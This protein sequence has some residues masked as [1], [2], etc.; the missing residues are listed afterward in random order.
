MSIRVQRIDHSTVLKPFDCGDNELNE[1]LQEKSKD[2][3]HGLLAA[4]FVVEDEIQ[5]L[6]YY[7]VRGLF[8]CIPRQ[9]IR[10]KRYTFFY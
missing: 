1:F 3:Q 5:T 6:A 7:T 10:E 4:T 2:Y 9:G 8:L